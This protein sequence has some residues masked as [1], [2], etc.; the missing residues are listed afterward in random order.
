MAADDHELL[1]QRQRFDKVL[2]ENRA[3][4]RREED[5]RVVASDGGERAVEYLGHDGHAALAAKAVVIDLTVIALR[6]VAQIHRLYIDQSAFDGSADDAGG[7]KAAEEFGK[8]GQYG[9]FH[10]SHSPSTRW[11]T[12]L[13]FS[14]SALRKNSG[15]AGT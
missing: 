11:M 1:F 9:D 4:R 13:R 12:T 5:F 6:K 2:R 10:S 3:G 14:R 8:G 7:Q 15:T